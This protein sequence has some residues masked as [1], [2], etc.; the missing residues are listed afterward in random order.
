MKKQTIN[1]MIILIAL[2]ALLSGC[3]D[4]MIPAGGEEAPAPGTGRVTIVI[5]GTGE[6]TILPQTPRN[7]QS[8]YF[9]LN[10]CRARRK[11][12]GYHPS[13]MWRLALRNRQ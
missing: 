7:S 10:Y 3:A 9:P 13:A 8:M 11:A 12:A 2:A 1:S 5:P 4:I 6:R